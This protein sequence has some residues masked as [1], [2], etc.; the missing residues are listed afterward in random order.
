M[1]RKFLRERVFSHLREFSQ[2]LGLQF[3]IVDIYHSLPASWLCQE[4]RADNEE[5]EE[6]GDC[7][8]GEEV[9]GGS[10]R[11]SVEESSRNGG[12]PLMCELELQGVLQLALK[13]IQVCQDM[14]AGPTFVVGGHMC[15][16]E[17]VLTLLTFSQTLQA[18]K[19]GH[20]PLP[21][22][23]PNEEFTLLCDTMLDSADERQ[24]VQQWYQ[25]DSNAMPPQY[26]LLQHL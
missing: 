15:S 14:S 7:I 4:T 17:C 5:E 2:S 6:K 1:E 24:L 18:Q 25:L 16:Y 19:Y 10:S 8:E 26:T 22:H 23:I 11:L 3:H 13:E 9:G 21:V 12:I 20:K